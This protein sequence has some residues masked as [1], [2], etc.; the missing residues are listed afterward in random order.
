[1]QEGTS[2]VESGRPCT[3]APA[4]DG[5]LPPGYPPRLALPPG[6]VVTDISRQAGLDLVTGRV[7]APVDAVLT[8][9]RESAEPAGFVVTRDEDEGQAGRLQ[10]FG[11][12]SEI[13]VTV[14]RLGCPRGATGF[15]VQVPAA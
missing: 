14:A 9:F 4:S 8:H 11:A 1:V 2:T 15:T 7:D 13:G 12:T 10:L 3:P 5:A 6:A